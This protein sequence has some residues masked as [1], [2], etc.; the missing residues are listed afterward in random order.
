MNKGDKETNISSNLKKLNNIKK[1]LMSKHT[2]K[3]MLGDDGNHAILNIEKRHKKVLRKERMKI[4]DI[5]QAVK[6]F[7]Q[8]F[9]KRRQLLK[10][11]FQKS[12]ERMWSRE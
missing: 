2:L 5:Y 11:N 10:T 6:Y 9:G 4:N 12:K 7:N 8:M 1:R 3:D